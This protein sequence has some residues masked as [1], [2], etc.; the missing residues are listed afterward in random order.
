LRDKDLNGSLNI[1]IHIETLFSIRQKLFQTGTAGGRLAGTN[2]AAATIPLQPLFVEHAVSATFS[3]IIG[4][5]RGS[6]IAKGQ[7]ALVKDVASN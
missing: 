7:T 3:G 6:E 4:R 1:V 5:L 2:E